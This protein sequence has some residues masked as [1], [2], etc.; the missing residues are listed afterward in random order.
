MTERGLIHRFGEPLPL[1]RAEAKRWLGGKGT[2]VAEMTRMGLPVPPGVTLSTDVWRHF[3]A[4]DALPDGLEAT[5]REQVAWIG[6]RVDAR[7]GDAEAP[8]L[9]AVRS[10]APTSMPGMLETVLDVGVDAAIARGLG[11]RYGEPRFGLDVRRRFVESYATVVLGVP[12]DAFD[13]VLGRRAVP[14]LDARELDAL[15]VE[16]ERLVAHEVGEGVPD[17]PW[18]QLFGA[19][20]GV[21]RSWRSPRAQKYREAHGVPYD[22]GTGVTVQAMVYGNL[23]PRSGAGVAFTRNPSTGERVLFGEW[24]PQ[25]QGEDV[26]SGRRTPR[27]L[28]SAQ[29]RRGLEDTSLETEM[30]EVLAELRALC[31]RLEQRHGDVQDVEVTIERGALWVLQCRAAKRTA[32]AAARIAV[33]MVEEGM[34]SRAE[35]LGRIDPPSLRQLLTPRL[36]DPVALA[37]QGLT[38]VARGLAASPGAAT[39]RLVLDAAAA[40]RQTGELVLV[41]AETSAEDVET[42]RTVSGILTAAG[43]LTSHAAV[44]ARAMGKPCVAGATSLHVDYARRVVVARGPEGGTQEL[45]EGD[46]VTID[47]A[48]GLVYAAEV[49]VEP[50]PASPHVESILAWADEARRAQVW[51]DATSPRLARVGRSF[52][53]DGVAIT[54]A[55]AEPIA[56]LREAAGDGRLAAVAGADALDTTVTA[57]RD[58]DALIVTPGDLARARAAVSERD[59]RV[60]LDLPL[61]ALDETPPSADGIVV[62]LED[63]AAIERL[64]AARAHLASVRAILLRGDAAT[65]PEAL[66]AVGDVPTIGLV[67]APLDVPIG[68]LRA[69]LAVAEPRR[70]RNEPRTGRTIG[71]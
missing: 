68:R 59:L 61:E 70:G 42:M 30:P 6:E 2:S 54:R 44:V 5:L 23:G 17:D 35:A 8:L 39:G 71:S 22:E 60:F 24:L 58:G 14:E 38:P 52:G 32:R 4:H 57:L 41:R 9:L 13:A 40:E 46:T 27:P 66:A 12:R 36:P 45:R 64:A 48:R 33:E 29:V 67:V 47:G 63:E 1:D 49:P 65:A 37:E 43:G 11:A 20:E 34:L 53:A 50:A 16:Y 7:F 51:A 21:L 31:E 62:A 15:L 19:L 25:A 55:V 26:V 10:G 3:D 28:T 56:H 69:A 18:A